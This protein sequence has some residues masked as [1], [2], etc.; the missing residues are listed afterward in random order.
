MKWTKRF[1]VE[2]GYYWV[3]VYDE[4]TMINY[5]IHYIDATEGW[6]SLQEAILGHRPQTL[7]FYGPIE[8]PEFTGIGFELKN[9]THNGKHYKEVEIRLGPSEDQNEMD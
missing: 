3:R 5:D 4:S 2:N 7:C 6:V 1:P 9:V 8:P